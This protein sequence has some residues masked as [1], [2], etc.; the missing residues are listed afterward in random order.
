MR[1]LQTTLLT[2]VFIFGLVQPLFAADTLACWFPPAWESKAPQAQAIAKA[3]STGAGM[4]IRPRIAKSYPEI[5]KAFDSTDQNLIY[6]GSFVQAII[7]ARKL[8]TPLVQ[9]MNGKELYSGVLIAPKGSDPKAI[10]S[11]TPKQIAFAVGASSGESSAKA[12]TDGKAA[13][14]VANHGAAVSA[15]IE[16]QAKAAVVKNWWWEAHAKDYPTMEMSLIAGVSI[17][18]NPDNVLTASKAVPVI[19]QDKIKKAA[20]SNNAAFGKNA[21]M[22]PFDSGKLAFS[23]GLMQKGKIDPINYRW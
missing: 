19:V 20:M 4:Q 18:G 15:V 3:L 13:I 6:V 8:G 9:N 5:L 14:G 16:G 23:L 2:L 21:N 12:A 22:Q 11:N 17:Q 10:L 1:K 7:A